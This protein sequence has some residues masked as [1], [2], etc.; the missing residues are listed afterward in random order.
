MGSWKGN[1]GDEERVDDGLVEGFLLTRLAGLEGGHRDAKHVELQ[2]REQL[3]GIL[4]RHARMRGICSST[5]RIKSRL[6]WMSGERQ[7]FSWH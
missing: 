6:P 7:L 4:H 2:L 3:D 5:G 1:L